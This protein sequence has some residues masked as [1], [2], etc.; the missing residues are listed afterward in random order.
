MRTTGI[1]IELGEPSNHLLLTNYSY[2]PPYIDTELVVW[3]ILNNK[4]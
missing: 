4:L 1:A 3:S 2:Y